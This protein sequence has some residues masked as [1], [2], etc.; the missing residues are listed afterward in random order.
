M[1][2]TGDLSTRWDPWNE[3]ELKLGR[4]KTTADG[5]S[6]PL[7]TMGAFGAGNPAS[8]NPLMARSNV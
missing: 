4:P 7:P 2:E 6:Q 3:E 1:E 5:L 8:L